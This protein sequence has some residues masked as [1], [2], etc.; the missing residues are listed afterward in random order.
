VKKPY[1]KPLLRSQGKV[2]N[3]SIQRVAISPIMP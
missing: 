1:S 3:V 2:K